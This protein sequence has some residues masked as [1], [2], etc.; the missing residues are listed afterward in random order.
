[1]TERKRDVSGKAY[2]I[3]GIL[4]T[5]ILA[6]DPMSTIKEWNGDTGIERTLEVAENMMGE[7]ID[8]I[9]ALETSLKRVSVDS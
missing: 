4:R 1:M 7:L 2:Q 5:C 9:E 6:C 3:G 8:E